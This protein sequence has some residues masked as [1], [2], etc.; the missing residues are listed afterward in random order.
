MNIIMSL[1]AVVVIMGAAYLG[2]ENAGMHV[3]FGTVLP[4][5]GMALFVVGMIYR[6]V[7]WAKSPV[8][9]R[10]TTTS[11]Q[12]KSLPW[13]KQDKVENPSTIFGVIVRM[14]LEV[15]FFRSLFRN[16]KLQLIKD[17]KNTKVAYASAYGLW[18]FSLLFHWSFFFVFARHLRFFADP[19]P[20]FV[21]VLQQ[22]DGFLEIGVPVLYLTGIFL[23]L[24]GVYLLL[25]RLF[26]AQI[27]YISLGSDYFPLF[28]IL[29]IGATGVLLRYFFKTDVVGVKE[30]A[31]G[32]VTFSPV[33]PEG[34]GSLFYVHLFLVTCLFA[35]FPF[36]K[37]VH[38]AGV[39]FS[40]TR[41]MT[42]NSREK[43]HINP[44]NDPNI[45]PHSY[46][47]YE[48]EFREK[49]KNVGIPV[50]KE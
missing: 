36:S 45:K 3:V 10:I 18:L 42:G 49:M 34:V 24:G 32:L 22:I 8:P 4:Y 30:L 38:G 11:G 44:W 5:I 23:L 20:S 39:L 15:L 50:D 28:L 43:R 26:S 31:M 6:V 12:Q 33:S 17:G 7:Y 1:V 27:R 46:A 16:T 47:A 35:Y 19:V 25:R 48:D 21:L 29:A 2:V 37:L 13:I 9:F 14:V 40:P 41:N